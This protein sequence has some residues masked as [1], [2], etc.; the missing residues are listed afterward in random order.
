MYYQSN[1]SSLSSL[2]PLFFRFVL[3]DFHFCKMW[4]I[5]I[6][7]ILFIKITTYISLLLRWLYIYGIRFRIYLFYIYMHFLAWIDETII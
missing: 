2:S 7:Q 6:I 3:L 4:K 5:I 1:A